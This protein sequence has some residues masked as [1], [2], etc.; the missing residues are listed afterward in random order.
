MAKPKATQ[1]DR[2]KFKVVGFR[3]PNRLMD[4]IRNLA[5][6]NRRTL[7]AE[8]ELALEKHLQEAGRWPLK[9]QNK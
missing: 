4:A 5:S 9:D 6:E 2:H 8:I 7:T 3:L 1:A